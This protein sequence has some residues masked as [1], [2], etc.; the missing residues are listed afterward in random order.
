MMLRIPLHTPSTQYFPFPQCFSA[1][2]SKN[3]ELHALYSVKDYRIN[4]HFR[5]VAENMDI[6]YKPLTFAAVHP[7]PKKNVKNNDKQQKA[8]CESEIHYL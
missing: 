2:H 8:S 1:R 4:F 3:I 7:M 6:R 5:I